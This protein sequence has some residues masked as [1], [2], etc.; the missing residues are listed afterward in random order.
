MG[1]QLQLVAQSVGKAEYET[2]A[3]SGQLALARA[4][5]FNRSPPSKFMP[6]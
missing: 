2:A 4:V 6:I 3:A 5:V 1:Y